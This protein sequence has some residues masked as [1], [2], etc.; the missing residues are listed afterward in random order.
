M[1]G[2]LQLY[3]SR[4]YII[5]MCLGGRFQGRANSEEM[6]SLLGRFNR[7]RGAAFTLDVRKVFEDY[8]GL[9]V[10]SNLVKIGRVRIAE[11][12]RDLG[13]IDVLVINPSRR[14]V[15]AIECKDLSVARNPHEMA[16]E[17]QELFVGN[18]Q[19]AVVVRHQRRA[20]WVATNLQLVLDHYGVEPGPGWCVTPIL[21]V[22]EEM[23]TPHI[24]SPPMPVVSLRTL[25]H[26]FLHEWLQGD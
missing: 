24:H 9:V 17:L 14:R 12:G 1:W 4:S 21:V 25:R 19:P 7:E 5:H 26:Q 18:A 2:N 6:R 13:D 20:D 15:L 11:E 22:S 8:E 16:N 23:L 10:D 3:E